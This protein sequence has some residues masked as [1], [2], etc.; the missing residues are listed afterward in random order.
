MGEDEGRRTYVCDSFSGLPRASTA[1]DDD[2]WSEVHLFEVAQSEV[3]D[4][5]KR[6]VPLDDNVRFRKGYFSESLPNVHE[7][8]QAEGRQLA[9]LRGDGDM[10]ESFLDILYNLYDF[11]AVD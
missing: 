2:A 6:F 5:F 7:E 4:N 8:L 10:Y 1:D 9:V 11:V 3:E